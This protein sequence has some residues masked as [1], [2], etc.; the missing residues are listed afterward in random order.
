MTESG[1]PL[2]TVYGPDDLPKD[3]AEKLGEPGGYPYT[4]GDYPTM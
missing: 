3:L 4:R 2:K 1:F